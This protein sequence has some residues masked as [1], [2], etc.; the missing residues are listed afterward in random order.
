MNLTTM[1]LGW[2]QKSGVF[3]EKPVIRFQWIVGIIDYKIHPE[4]EKLKEEKMDMMESMQD[5]NPKISKYT[6][7]TKPNQSVSY[8]WS[9]AT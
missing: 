1:P 9:A 4:L 8:P 3:N 2:P 6:A 7:K 5:T